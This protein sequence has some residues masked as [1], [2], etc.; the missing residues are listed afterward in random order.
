MIEIRFDTK[1]DTLIVNEFVCENKDDI[2]I[3]PTHSIFPLIIPVFCKAFIKSDCSII[4]LNNER[5]WEKIQ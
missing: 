3:L 4:T 2:D 1:E 5:I